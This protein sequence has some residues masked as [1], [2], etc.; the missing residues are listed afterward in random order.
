MN[1][2]LL[3][4]LVLLVG[5]LVVGRIRPSHADRSAVATP[6]AA[7]PQPRSV[8]PPTPAAALPGPPESLSSSTDLLARLDARRRLL[9]AAPYTYFDSLFAETDSVVRRW[10]DREGVPFQVVMEAPDSAPVDQRIRATYVRAL[11]TWESLGIG[12]RF[13]LGTDTAGVQLILGYSE[14]L[15]GDRAGQTDLEWTRDG[16]I[17][18]AHVSLS[19]NDPQGRPNSDAVLLAVAVHEIGHALGLGHSPDPDDV[20][21]AATR[22]S[23]LST[24][25]RATL[26]LLYE[27]PLGQ[28]REIVTP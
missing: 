12:L 19:R 20:M 2:F 25:D 14:R 22:T 23:R 28:I 17:R 16:A 4:A 1:R 24:R 8:A 10:A 13:N 11:A 18:N 7:A 9:G 6:V 3:A 15:G 26:T 27:L 21:F 5:L